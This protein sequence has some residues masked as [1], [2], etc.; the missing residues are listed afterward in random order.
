MSDFF[1]LSDGSKPT[2]SEED[3]NLSASFTIANNTMAKAKILSFVIKTFGESQYLEVK[4]LLTDTSYKGLNVSQKIKVFDVPGKA[5]D[6][7]INMLVRLYKIAGINPSHSSI[8]TDKDLLVFKGKIMGIKVQQ[9]FYEG[10]EGNW[11]SAV[12]P[13]DDFKSEDGVML[14]APKAELKGSS[15]DAKDADVIFS[16]KPDFDDDVPF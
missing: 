8:P 11:V 1:T 6:R 5:R 4:W 9:W 10:K 14:S 15:Y 3:A 12:Y 7:A 16:N 13:A 2:G